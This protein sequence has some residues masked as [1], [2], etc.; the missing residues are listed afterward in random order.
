MGWGGWG[1][2]GGGGGGGIQIGQLADNQIEPVIG[3]ALLV[4]LQAFLWLPW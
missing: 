1:C 4:F 3:A 2:G